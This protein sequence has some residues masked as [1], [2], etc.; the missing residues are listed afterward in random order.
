MKT[1][2]QASDGKQFDTA[3]ACETYE[4]KFHIK[5]SDVVPGAKFSATRFKATVTLIEVYPPGK[6][7]FGSNGN[8]SRA[9]GS[10]HETNGVSASEILNYLQS[11]GYEKVQ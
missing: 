6:F 5:A 3:C 10:F 2:Y 4:K 11:E 1:I 9:Y 7:L 8:P